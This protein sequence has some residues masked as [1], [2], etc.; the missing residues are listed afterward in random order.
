MKVRNEDVSDIS[1]EGFLKG[2]QPDLFTELA[3][4]AIKCKVGERRVLMD[5][6]HAIV[7]LEVKGTTLS[8]PKS[9][10]DNPSDAD[11]KKTVGDRDFDVAEGKW[12]KRVPQSVTRLS[13]EEILQETDAMMGEFIEGMDRL[14]QEDLAK[15]GGSRTKTPTGKDRR[16]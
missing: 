14:F 8:E 6:T 10:Q 12:K 7:N 13:D 5:V 16:K 3:G 11:G 9:G 4:N 2:D 1:K 15:E